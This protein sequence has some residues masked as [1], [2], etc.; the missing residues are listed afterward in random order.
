M[1][2]SRYGP[3]VGIRASLQRAGQR[4]AV[5]PG[6]FDDRVRL[7]QQR[8]RAL[9]DLLAGGG[10]GDALGLALDQRHA[11]VFLELAD[12]RRQGRLADE[13]AL[14]GLAEMTLVGQGDQVTEIT[15]VHAEIIAVVY[16][17]A[18]SHQAGESPIL[19]V[20]SLRSTRLSAGV[21]VVRRQGDDWL[22]L[23][24]RAFN[25]WDF[26]KGM[27][28]S[29][30]EPL[31]A[32]IRE[33]EE[34][35]T[36]AD[37]DFAWGEDSTQTGPYS[38]G[39]I[40]RYLP[41]LDAD[42]R[43][44]AA[45]QPADRPARAQRVPLGRLRRSARARLAARQAGAALGG[46]GAC[47]RSRRRLIRRR[48]RGGRRAG[49]PRRWR[50]S[51]R[52]IAAGP[53][54]PPRRCA[55]S[56]SGS[57]CRPPAA[58]RRPSGGS[59]GSTSIA[60]PPSSPARNAAASA[61]ES[62]SAPRA[63][64][65]SSASRRMR[66]SLAAS[67]RPCVRGVSGQC[68][69]STSTRGSSSSRS[70]RPGCRAPPGRFGDQHFHAERQRGRARDGLAQ[71]AVPDDAEPAAGQFAQRIVEQQ[72]CSPR[73]HAPERTS[74]VVLAQA[75]VQQQQHAER[76]LHHRRRAVV[77]QVADADA[78]LACRLEVDIV[79]AGR[80]QHQQLQLGAAFDDAA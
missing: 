39:K 43:C 78:A 50:P 17:R 31:A 20:M 66:P 16:R 7:L 13:A 15:Q 57:E 59:R 12:L 32:A 51:H 22:Y 28:E 29:G 38:G 58:D 73:C 23:L 79:G 75:L 6:Q 21:V 54:A 1:C 40:A 56:R 60:A 44:R 74:S 8:A 49:N 55:V 77:A 25:H 65:T 61:A 37:L 76:V 19:R 69:L 36:I 47:A 11:E 72:N 35:S 10:Q 30:E 4:I 62:T 63:V 70:R 48:G 26:P 9:H 5:G 14:G 80:R 2:G 3:T 33:V 42:Q 24:L 45:G 64:F 71:H 27:V 18:Q 67:S 68:R 52:G 53:R 34:E 41:G 46:A